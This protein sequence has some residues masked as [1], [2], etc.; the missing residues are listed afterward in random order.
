M[1]GSPVYPTVHSPTTPGQQ[2]YPG[3]LT[4][5]SLSRASFIASPRW[6]GPS[7]FAQLMVPHGVVQVPGWSTYAVSTALLSLF[8][9]SPLW[10][11]LILIFS[12]VLFVLCYATFC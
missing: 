2:S 7:S 9:F 4:N 8:R 5:W 1:R 11:F 6:Q 3:G 10:K 12:I